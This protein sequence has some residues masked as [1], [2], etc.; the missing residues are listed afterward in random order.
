MGYLQELNEKQIGEAL[1]GAAERQIPVT[2]TIR[3]G[4]RWVNLR[5]RFLAICGQK[6]LLEPPSGPEG[7]P[8][9]EFGPAQKVGLSFKYKHHK[10]IFSTTVIGNDKVVLAENTAAPGLAL[11]RPVRMERLQQ[12][13]ILGAEIG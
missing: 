4:Q 3:R 10:H 12:A 5:S 9:Q 11:D 7:A 1:V 6:L 13:L 8:P 2:V